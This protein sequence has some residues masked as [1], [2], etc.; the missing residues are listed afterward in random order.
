MADGSSGISDPSAASTTQARTS[1]KRQ[2]GRAFGLTA[3]LLLSVAI[4][5]P[6]D[7]T[8]RCRRGELP[9]LALRVSH[10][11]WA[12]AVAFCP[13]EHRGRCSE[14]AVAID[15]DACTSH[16]GGTPVEAGTLPTNLTSGRTSVQTIIP[17]TGKRSSK[18]TAPFSK[19]EHIA[20]GL[21][22]QPPPR[23]VQAN[24]A[25]IAFLLSLNASLIEE[26]KRHC[27]A[28]GHDGFSTAP[29]GMTP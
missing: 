20:R 12:D 9:R 18:R 17:N 5:L 1:P 27:S 3:G 11:N 23:I 19:T 10:N 4:L 25:P 22:R 21:L 16:R 15:C 7:I 14:L 13:F 28:N 29:S 8:V 6:V 26:A 2:L 24:R